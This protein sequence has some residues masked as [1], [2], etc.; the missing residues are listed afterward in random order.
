MFSDVIAVEYL[1]KFRLR[2]TFEDGFSGTLDLQPYLPT[3]G[4]FAPLAD[5]AFFSQVRINPDLGTICWE[6]G[7]DIDPAV[8]YAWISGKEIPSLTDTEAA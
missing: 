7:A 6:T 1:G 5:P 4:V 2:I 8:L 3:T